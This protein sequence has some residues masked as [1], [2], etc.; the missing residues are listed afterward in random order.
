MAD[1]SRALAKLVEACIAWQEASRD[2]RC[3][4][5]RRIFRR[6][7]DV[8]LDQAIDHCKGWWRDRQ[9]AAEAPTVPRGRRTLR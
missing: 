2:V 1:L 6:Q 7:V 9:A 4:C 5:G 8:L 3:E